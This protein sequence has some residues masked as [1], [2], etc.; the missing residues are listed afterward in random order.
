MICSK[1][2]RLEHPSPPNNIFIN[3]CKADSLH[4]RMQH[5]STQTDDTAGNTLS[6]NEEGNT[7][8]ETYTGV[9]SGAH[10]NHQ[11]SLW[12]ELVLITFNVEG[13]YR[14]SF[15]LTQIL[16]L[17]PKIVFLQE[18]WVPYHK[19]SSMNKKFPSY[20]VQISTPDQL[21]PPEDRLSNPDHTWHGAAVLWHESLNSSLLQITNTNVRF[22]GIK[23]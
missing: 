19:E 12:L 6:T 4:T 20:S 23:I 8:S 22:T 13:F 9:T 14:N 7:S 2:E 1:I 5:M 10:T 21:T 16:N 3:S 11:A 15:Y 18:I 17:A